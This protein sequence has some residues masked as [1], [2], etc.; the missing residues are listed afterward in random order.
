MGGGSGSGGRGRGGSQRGD[1]GATV[2]GTSCKSLR[3]AGGGFEP[4]HHPPTLS[5]AVLLAL[6]CITDRHSVG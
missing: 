4:L 5:T 1:E 3:M 2:K 6:V